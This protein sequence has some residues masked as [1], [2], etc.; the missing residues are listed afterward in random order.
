MEVPE[1][2]DLQRK[3]ALSAV[4]RQLHGDCFTKAHAPRYDEL[5]YARLFIS[6]YGNLS[7]IEAICQFPVS[8]L[9]LEIPK[10]ANLAAIREGLIRL[11]SGLSESIR[12]LQIDYIYDVTAKDHDS[13]HCVLP[14]SGAVFARLP[15]LDQIV[16]NRVNVNDRHVANLCKNKLISAMDFREGD[17][18]LDCI[19][20]IKS[21]PA[22]RYV[23]F[24]GCAAIREEHLSRV[25]QKLPNVEIVRIVDY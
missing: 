12:F 19:K 20:F 5:Q 11:V 14:N 23:M 21:L 13:L 25:R 10:T 22:L 24:E 15:K 2:F 17:V 3:R 6:E 7:A 18:T 8:W 1:V 16:F 9:Q 4:I